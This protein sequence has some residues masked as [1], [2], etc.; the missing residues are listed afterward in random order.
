MAANDGQ[1]GGS[2][3]RLVRV[4]RPTPLAFSL[5]VD[6][7]REKLSSEK[8]ADRV[9]RMLAPLERAADRTRRG[10]GSLRA[11]RRVIR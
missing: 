7:T 11:A 4:E 8:L 6:R 3:V 1:T 5:I 2:G 9:R 10:Q